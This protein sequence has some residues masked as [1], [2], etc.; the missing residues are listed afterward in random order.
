[1]AYRITSNCIHCQRCLTVCPTG[2]VQE[3]GSDLWIDPNRCTNCAGSFSS[4]LCAAVCPTNGGCLPSL[5]DYWHGWF[6][7]YRQQVAR[8]QPVSSVPYWERW[9]DRY[10]QS[11]SQLLQARQAAL[12]PRDA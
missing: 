4:A 5:K 12:T 10:S 3:Y 11:L 8:L 6:Q 7:R 9:F 1:M 2:A